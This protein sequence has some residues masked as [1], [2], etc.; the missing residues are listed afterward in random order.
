M[1]IRIIRALGAALLVSASA[2]SS[3][4][5]D[6]P[7]PTASGQADASA[8]EEIVVTARRRSERIEKVPVSITAFSKDE[9]AAHEIRTEADLQASVPGLTIRQ[10]VSQ[11]QLNY[12]IRGQSIDAY[13]GSAPGV[14]PYIDELQVSANTATSFYD[15]E[16]VQILKG[17]QGTLFGRNATGGAVL[18]QTVRPHDD[19]EGYISAGA[20]NYGAKSLEGAINLPLATDK[21]LIRVAGTYVESD[22]YV[23]NLY[24]NSW[25]GGQNV[26]SGR[27]T[28]LLKPIDDLAS[29]TTGQFGDYGGT[30]TPSELYSANACGSTNN[31]IVLLSAVA[32]LYDPAFP[33]FAAF[34]ATHP[35]AYPGGVTAFVDYQRSLGP[36]RADVDFPARHSAQSGFIVNNTTYDLTSEITIKNILGVTRS[37]SAEQNDFDGTP[38]PI[39]A[40]GST[41]NPRAEIFNTDQF[42][43]ELQ[44]Q[45]KAFD[46]DL[47]YIVGAYYGYQHDQSD[48]PLFAFDLAPVIPGTPF[49][50][51]WE[52]TDRTRAGFTQATY[53][54]GGGFSITGGFRYTRDTVDIGELNQSIFAGAPVEHIGSSKPSWTAGLEYQATPELMLYATTRGS[55]RSGGFNGTSPPV[56]AYASG[57][58]NVFKPETTRDVEIGAKYA[59]DMLDIPVRLNL[60]GYNQWVSDIQRTAYLILNGNPLA[61]TVN[62]PEAEITGAEFNGEVKPFSAL[63]IGGSLAYAYARYTSPMVSYFGNTLAFGPYGDTPRLSGTLFVQFTQELGADFGALIFRGDIYSQTAQYFSNLDRTINPGTKLPGY[64]LANLRVDWSGV[65][66]RDVDISFYVRNLTDRRYWVGGIPQGADLGLNEASP[67]RPRMFGATVRYDF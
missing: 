36:W 46:D 2:T 21:A 44:L 25:L 59:G 35:K 18:Y 45:G 38:Y 42:S 14:L 29:T 28:L 13:S 50:Y 64:A 61:I 6:A 57:G 9:L 63:T 22:G 41:A 31:G 5:E 23:H 20:G 15:L 17:P 62:V 48:Y 11:N 16:S 33:G 24:N 3:M 43:D 52:V 32:C 47:T 1:T 66:A 26:L 49:R 53:K 12:S 51:H 40:A 7:T 34:L 55:W 39:F 37:R 8:F 54:L 65:M 60:S 58:G 10:T 30:N 4:A 56:P 19:F 67:G 27:A